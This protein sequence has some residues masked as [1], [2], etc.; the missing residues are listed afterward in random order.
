[1]PLT[2]ER[3]AE[4]AQT[5]VWKY[6]AVVRPDELL[7][8]AEFR[9]VPDWLGWVAFELM[10]AKINEKTLQLLVLAFPDD[11]FLKTLT[12]VELAQ[13]SDAVKKEYEDNKQKR[14]QEWGKAVRGDLAT[15][16]PA[17]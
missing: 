12:L 5:L 2:P 13:L 10:H 17:W 3:V 1:M 7:Q 16:P 9:H 11:E 14:L 4:L 15:P 6:D 8:G